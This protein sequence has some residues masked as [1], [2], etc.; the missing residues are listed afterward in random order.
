MQSSLHKMMHG[1]SIPNLKQTN[2][3]NGGN[4]GNGGNVSLEP[5]AT[6]TQLSSHM[7]AMKPSCVI[8]FNGR[9]STRESIKAL[10]SMKIDLGEHQID[11]LERN[12]MLDYLK[13][14]HYYLM[15]L[16]KKEL[17][18]RIILTKWDGDVEA[19]NLFWTTLES[20]LESHLLTIEEVS[21]ELEAYKSFFDLEKLSKI[22]KVLFRHYQAR[23][24]RTFKLKAV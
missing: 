2:I 9:L 5:Y 1:D 20:S 8:D 12:S 21:G 19:S 17:L 7:S 14:H 4:G 3:G 18:N 22:R 16:S 13:Q 15:L 6:E 11:D 24:Q 10:N 23:R